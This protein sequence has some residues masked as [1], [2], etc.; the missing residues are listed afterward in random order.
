MEK[1]KF[2]INKKDKSKIKESKIYQ[3]AITKIRQINIRQ[4]KDRIKNL[5]KVYKK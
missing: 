2:Y 5:Y 3:K 4:N 1:K